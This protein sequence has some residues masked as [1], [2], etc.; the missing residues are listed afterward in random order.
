MWL[1]KMFDSI[2]KKVGRRV[3][4]FFNCWLV[5]DQDGPN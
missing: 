1:V 2:S 4:F 3:F 5:V